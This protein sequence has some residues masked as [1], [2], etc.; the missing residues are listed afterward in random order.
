MNELLKQ[1]LANL[2]IVSYTRIDKIS[3]KIPNKTVTLKRH[4][5]QTLYGYNLFAP[6]AYFKQFYL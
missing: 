1:G 2:K 4:T 3:R 6:E 5:K